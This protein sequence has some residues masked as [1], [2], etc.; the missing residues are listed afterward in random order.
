MLALSVKLTESAK[1]EQWETLAG[2]SYNGNDHS[3][4]L[5]AHDVWGTNLT[6]NFHGLEPFLHRGKAN[7][8]SFLYCEP[9]ECKTMTVCSIDDQSLLNEE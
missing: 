7:A 4:I 2:E 3:Q 6:I 8:I 1:S 5:V 9:S